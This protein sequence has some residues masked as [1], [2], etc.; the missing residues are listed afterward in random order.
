MPTLFVDNVAFKHQLSGQA[1]SDAYA[2]IATARADTNMRVEELLAGIK[3]DDA[4]LTQRAGALLIEGSDARLASAITANKKLRPPYR[5]TLE[6]C[7]AVP[8]LL[9]FSKPLPEPVPVYAKKKN[10]GGVRMIHKPGLLHRT[11]QD[12][13][14]RIM[15]AHYVPKPFQFTHRGVHRA[16]KQ[17][18]VG[19]TEGKVFV[20][21]LDIKDF[22]SSFE[23]EKLV[24]ELPLPQEVVEHVV[25]GRQIEVVMD[26]ESMKGSCTAISS[27]PHT[28]N[29]L[30]L[31]ARRGIPLGSACSPIVGAFCMSRLK[32]VPIDGVLL[33]NYVDDFLLLSSSPA[34]LGTAV[35]QLTDAVADLP[36]GQFELQ[37][38]AERTAA[39]GFEFLGHRLQVVEGKLKTKPAESATCELYEQLDKIEAKL[40]KIVYVP[41]M[42]FKHDQGEAI[43]HLAHMVAKIDGWLR[44]FSECDN[45]TRDV[46][47][48][49]M[50]INEWC[51]KLGV[52][53][54]QLYDAI[55]P[56]MGYRWGDY[57]FR[58]SVQN[59]AKWTSGAAAA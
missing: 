12:M 44:A 1:L 9:D 42:A 15:S 30:V 20:A 57:A 35:G 51:S 16:I 2:Q 21:R 54:A 33:V 50:A 47:V 6:R 58:A 22:Y 31:L 14:E 28:Y 3:A 49:A 11:A 48:W 18:K 10:S 7:L 52:S 38:K 56:F 13:V 25:V 39:K 55:E 43:K 36:G 4:F 24:T 59:G 26:K 53:T 8:A 45:P 40:I 27:L 19:L 17:A 41:G 37:L 5:Q 46:Q 23:V 34:L 29:T 32:W